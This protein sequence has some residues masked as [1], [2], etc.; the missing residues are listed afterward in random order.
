LQE[1]A[2]VIARLLLPQ[3]FEKMPMHE[4]RVLITERSTISVYIRGETIEIEQNHVGILL[5]GY[6]RS[7]DK[8]L[9]KPPG[10]LLPSNSDWSS[11]GLESTGY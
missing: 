6:L 3:I 1:S 9:I 2:L 4:I 11:F 5:E 8:N 10:V 7:E